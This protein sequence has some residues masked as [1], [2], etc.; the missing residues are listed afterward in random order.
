MDNHGHFPYVHA[1]LGRCQDRRRVYS[2]IF[3]MDRKSNALTQFSQKF[4]N[5]IVQINRWYNISTSVLIG[6]PSLILDVIAISILRF[7]HTY[8]RSIQY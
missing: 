6:L 5:I 3:V 4:L 7:L 1:G 2:W 8:I